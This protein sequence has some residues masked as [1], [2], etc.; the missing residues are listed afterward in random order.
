[1]LNRKV[2]YGVFFFIFFVIL[3]GCTGNI[4]ITP[5]PDPVIE[6]YQEKTNEEGVA[7]ISFE[8]NNGEMIN[9]Q[10]K[11]TDNETLELLEDID[12]DLVQNENGELVLFLTDS[13]GV[14]I[15]KIVNL[16]LSKN[17]YR[18]KGVEDLIPFYS[19][20]E[21]LV[22]IH[23]A[24]T[25]GVLDE[26]PPQKVD[27]SIFNFLFDKYYIYSGRFPLSELKYSWDTAMGST[28]GALLGLVIKTGYKSVL[29]AIDVVDMADTF[30]RAEFVKKL[31]SKGYQDDDILEL[32]YTTSLSNITNQGAYSIPTPYIIPMGQPGE[33]TQPVIEEIDYNNVVEEYEEIEIECFA[34]DRDGRG[35]LEYYWSCNCDNEEITYKQGKK[36]TWQAPEYV[37]FSSDWSCLCYFTCEVKDQ[38]GL[39]DKEKFTINVTDSTSTWELPSFFPEIVSLNPDPNTVGIHP[40]S[41]EITC[42]T[43]NQDGYDLRYEWSASAGYF[44]GDTDKS[45]VEWFAPNEPGICRITCKVINIF[46]NSDTKSTDINVE[47]IPPPPATLEGLSVFPNIMSF[48]DI[49]I[50]KNIDSV[51]LF[52]SDNNQTYIMEGQ[53]T[54]KSLNSSVAIFTGTG[55]IKIKSIGPG[56]TQIK[57]SYT[58]SNNVTKY[59]YIDVHVDEIPLTKTLTSLTVSPDSMSFTAA[60]QSKDIQEI[61]LGWLW[62]DG[63][64]STSSLAEGN[65]TYYVYDSSVADVTGTN[66]VKVQSVGEGDTQIK[67]SYTYNGVTK[68]DYIDVIV[69]GGSDGDITNVSPLTDPFTLD[70]WYTTNVY[71]KNIGN[72]SHTFTVNASEPSGTDFSVNQKNITLS[73]GASGTVS[74]TYKF[75]GTETCRSLTFELYDSSSNLLKTYETESLCPTL[76]N[77]TV[78]TVKVTNITTTSARL[79]GNI[80]NTGGENCNERGFVL[81]D[82]TSGTV[83]GTIYTTGSYSTGEYYQTKSGLISGHN[84]RFAAYADNSHG[85]GTGDWVEFTTETELELDYIQSSPSST[86]L[87]KLHWFNFS[88]DYVIKAYFS[89]GHVETW[90]NYTKFSFS[91]SNENIAYVDSAGVH[92]DVF[93]IGSGTATITITYREDTSKKAYLTVTV[94]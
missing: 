94:Y 40:S 3:V 63:A 20:V 90:T 84:Y 24:L 83:V 27:Q 89:D 91:T 64:T 47:E 13:E 34:S 68:Y 28:G 1:M 22:N 66:S 30:M 25:S 52:W 8:D 12:V 36:I 88:S 80:T 14:Y 17:Y 87:Q 51:E 85:T 11:T 77:P 61:I 67:V 60:G 82:L 71:V 55:E 86:N 42:N 26:Y 46:G 5:N 16:G 74:F 48:S 76:A 18:E 45:K 50:E 31:Q 75:Y 43:Q 69:G 32:Y 38:D 4:G 54:Y 23:Q 79:Y 39:S 19:I 49:G 65:A 57:V 73:A 10:I 92:G 7:N 15:P 81:Q 70:T 53:A 21:K 58:D 93:G 72:V 56:D 6:V 2:Y 35:S 9:L 29:I 33:F 44:S 41:A 78:T 59:N 37:S 62:S